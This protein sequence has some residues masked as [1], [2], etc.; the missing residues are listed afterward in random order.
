MNRDWAASC[1][2]Q[3][4]APDGGGMLLSDVDTFLHHFRDCDVMFSEILRKAISPRYQTA[5]S[6]LPHCAWATTGVQE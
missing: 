1:I 4:A 6:T 5:V 3:P 2:V